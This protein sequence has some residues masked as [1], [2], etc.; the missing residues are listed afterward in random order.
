M[1][2]QLEENL[3]TYVRTLVK[4]IDIDFWGNGRFLIHTD[5]QIVSH[6]EGRCCFFCNL[7]PVN[8]CLC[9]F[10]CY[11]IYYMSFGLITF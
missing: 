4:D 11:C 1:S 7:G 3:L 8:W 5:R 2:L 6:K 9:T 10:P